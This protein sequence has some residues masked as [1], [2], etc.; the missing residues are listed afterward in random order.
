MENTPP[1]PSLQAELQNTAVRDHRFLAGMFADGY[2]PNPLVERGVS[3]LLEL[4]GEIEQH[5][6]EGDAVYVLTHAAT[7]RFNDL[8]EAFWEAG[9]EI[10]TAARECIAADFAFLL[11]AYGYAFDLEEAIATR[12]W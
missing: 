1:L 3:I 6:P 2:F 11:E 12:D 5:K 10:E 7:E 8:Q 9:S 4:C